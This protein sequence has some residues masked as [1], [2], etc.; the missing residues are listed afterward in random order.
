[1]NILV[2]HSSSQYENYQGDARHAFVD[3]YVFF[4]MTTYTDK[5]V[6]INKMDVAMIMYISWSCFVPRKSVT[7]K[8]FVTIPGSTAVVVRSVILKTGFVKMEVESF[9]VIETL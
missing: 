9:E 5:N 8:L 3:N 1:M 6:H 4:L 2:R 7:F